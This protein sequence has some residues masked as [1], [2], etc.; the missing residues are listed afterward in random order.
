M[1]YV[2]AESDAE[3]NRVFEDT[4]RYVTFADSAEEESY[5]SHDRSF[6]EL[7]KDVFARLLGPLNDDQVHQNEDWWPNHTRYVDCNL[8]VF[9]E[10]LQRALHSL[11]CGE[12]EG[13]RIQIVVYRDMLDG[14]TQVG[15]MVLYSDWALVDRQLYDELKNCRKT[16]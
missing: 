13:W 1:R 14:A 9:N 4:G 16:P 6:I 7:I 15:S 11:L 10:H 3:F 2:V 12:Y 5:V 8:T